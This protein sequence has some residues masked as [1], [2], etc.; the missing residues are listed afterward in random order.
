MGRCFLLKS[1]QANRPITW[2]QK[3]TFKIR[4]DLTYEKLGAPLHVLTIQYTFE[5]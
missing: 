2:K 4:S 3:K 1:E 5:Y